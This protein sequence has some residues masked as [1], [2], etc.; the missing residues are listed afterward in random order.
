MNPVEP[1]TGETTRLPTLTPDASV[2][3]GTV[4]DQRHQYVIHQ[5]NMG[6]TVSPYVAPPP[7]A[8]QPVNPAG[9]FPAARLP[10]AASGVM[11]QPHYPPPQRGYING[12]APHTITTTN[13]GAQNP[14]R[15]VQA[16]AQPDARANAEPQLVS[17]KYEAFGNR[18]YSN[19]ARANDTAF[20]LLEKMPFGTVAKSFKELKLVRAGVQIAR[21]RLQT[22]MDRNTRIRNGQEVPSAEPNPTINVA[23]AVETLTGASLYAFSRVERLKKSIEKKRKKASERVRDV[24]GVR[25][26][27]LTAMWYRLNPG[28]RPDAQTPLPSRD[29]AVGELARV[30]NNPNS[31]QS[32]L[33]QILYFPGKLSGK[34]RQRNERYHVDDF[35]KKMMFVEMAR[36]CVSREDFKRLKKYYGR[37]DSR[38][39][40]RLANTPT[41]RYRTLSI[42]GKVLWQGKTPMAGSFEWD[43]CQNPRLKAMWEAFDPA[44]EKVTN[45]PE[46][47]GK[48]QFIPT[49]KY[50]DFAL[51][52]AG[53]YADNLDR[54]IQGAENDLNEVN[55]RDEDV[56]LLAS[57]QLAIENRR[58]SLLELSEPFAS[59]SNSLRRDAAHEALDTQL[60][61]GDQEHLRV[62]GYDDDQRAAY[63]QWSYGKMYGSIDLPRRMIVAARPRRRQLPGRPANAGSIE[64][65]SFTQSQLDRIR[66]LDP[67]M[68]RMA[69]LCA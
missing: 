68:Y 53:N 30:F 7:V 16:P 67:M 51:E 10:D 24:Q 45:K 65:T 29:Q 55:K 23:P 37:L 39:A 25:S 6:P 47:G 58:D 34:E 26:N 32:L 4:F 14:A 5:Y 15:Q 59:S 50:E 46:Y 42:L 62:L 49:T 11:P 35:R 31:R 13:L 64:L 19:I 8:H 56:A 28:R 60:R 18:F 40:K 20:G 69:A 17:E 33:A 63:N 1:V 2:H 3:V 36:N 66:K 9:V 12:Q 61:Q 38:Q 21:L 44:Y 43:V 52:L 54:K 48:R 22:I 41:Y 57:V 27:L